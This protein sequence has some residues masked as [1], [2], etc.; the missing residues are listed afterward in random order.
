MDV[1]KKVIL[2]DRADF[3]KLAD[4]QNEKAALALIGPLADYGKADV[5]VTN[6]GKPL[7]DYEKEV[8]E[9]REAYPA[10]R[11]SLGLDAATKLPGQ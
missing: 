3:K 8:R 5:T 11:K 1:L 7:F 2:M 9:A 10:L 4:A 6:L